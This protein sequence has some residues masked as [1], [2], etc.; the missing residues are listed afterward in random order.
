MSSKEAVLAGES[1]AFGPAKK[2]QKDLIAFRCPPEL[3]E[4][5]A[6]RKKESSV[7]MTD[8]IVWAVQSGREL[9][10]A[11]AASADEL[12]RIAR[13]EGLTRAAALKRVVERGIRAYVAERKQNTRR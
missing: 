11:T 8:A 4:W 5:L 1:V 12:E 10:E 6:E 7:T 2:R 3:V 13:E 9:F